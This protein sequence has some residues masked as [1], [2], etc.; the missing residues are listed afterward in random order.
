MPRLAAT[1]V[2]VTPFLKSIDESYQL[3]GAELQVINNTELIAL[4]IVAFFF[5]LFFYC[6]KSL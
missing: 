3:C 1:S 2:S 6:V 5:V 4:I